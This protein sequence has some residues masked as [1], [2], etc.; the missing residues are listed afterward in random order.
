[1]TLTVNC[2]EGNH[3]LMVKGKEISMNCERQV[4]SDIIS[5]CHL[6][7]SQTT[8][9]AHINATNSTGIKKHS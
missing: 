2:K 5:H 6:R 1:M 7:S 4:F 8:G 3:P 9:S